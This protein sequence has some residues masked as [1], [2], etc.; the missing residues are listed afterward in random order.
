MYSSARS[1]LMR[2][3]ALVLVVSLLATG[4]SAD[5]DGGVSQET[6]GGPYGT[7][8]AVCSTATAGV[9]FF[10]TP[11][12]APSGDLDWQAHVSG[13][14]EFDFENVTPGTFIDS[15]NAGPIT[16]DLSKA[17]AASRSA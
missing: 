1:S 17:L 14:T 16:V 10:L 12:Q 7:A 15:I 3:P 13:F 9:R 6:A 5:M 8:A 4:C 11:G 2:T